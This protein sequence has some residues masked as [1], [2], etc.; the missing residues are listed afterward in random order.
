MLQKQRKLI[1]GCNWKS[2]YTLE[3]VIN[4]LTENLNKIVFD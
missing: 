2:N 3:E 1:I 4:F